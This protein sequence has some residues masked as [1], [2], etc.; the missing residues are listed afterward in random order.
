MRK[1]IAALALSAAAAGSLMLAVPAHAA[2]MTPGPADGPALPGYECA[3]LAP[4]PPIPVPMINGRECA[5]VNG[6]PEGG[7]APGPVKI[8]N[9][10]EGMTWI[11]RWA[12]AEQY[13]ESVMG[14]DCFPEGMQ[15]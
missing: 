3:L 5:A 15:P 11:C 14:R 2:S 8:S 4:A 7:I 10:M 1:T 6:A 9:P 13:P 12:D